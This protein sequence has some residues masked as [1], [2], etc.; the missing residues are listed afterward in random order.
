M[1]PQNFCY[2]PGLLSILLLAITID[3]GFYLLQEDSEIQNDIRLP[4]GWGDTSLQIYKCKLQPVGYSNCACLFAT[5]ASGNLMITNL[6]SQRTNSIFG[7]CLYINKYVPFPNQS[8]VLLKFANTKELQSIFTNDVIIPTR[9]CE[10]LAAGFVS[11]SLIGLP[12]EIIT[13]IMILS[14]GV[15]TANLSHTNSRFRNIAY[16]KNL[17]KILLC[18]EHH[19]H[20]LLLKDTLDVN[21]YEEYIECHMN[22]YPKRIPRPRVAYGK[23]GHKF[24][25][26]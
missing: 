12:E 16:N 3:Y 14:G 25:P 1:C 18:K 20:Y 19:R 17:W 6:I 24:F 5:S 7:K 13:K 11:G 26:L 22:K 9:S 23:S 21:W 4:I 10:L 15:S 8:S 2:P